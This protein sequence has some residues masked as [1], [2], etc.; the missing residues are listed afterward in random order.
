M[1]V[2]TQRNADQIARAKGIRR[3]LI[4]EKLRMNH[5]VSII[6]RWSQYKDGLTYIANR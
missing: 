3:R 6:L 5:T 1:S 4:G 2:P